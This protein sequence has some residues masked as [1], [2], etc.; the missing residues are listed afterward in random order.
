MTR[1]MKL[2][3]LRGGLSAGLSVTAVLLVILTSLFGQ[4]T[5]L[6]QRPLFL[7]L[8]IVLGYARFPSKGRPSKIRGVVDTGLAILCGLACLA[9]I[10]R[11]DEIITSLPEANVM[12]VVSLA[13]I[14]LALLVLMVRI[15]GWAF[16]IMI[17]LSLIYSLYGNL[18]PGALGH[19]GLDM[20]FLVESLYLGDL[21]LW[22]MLTGVAAT[23]IAPFVL[24]GAMVLCTGGGQAFR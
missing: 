3:R 6:I 12:D 11:A 9:V 20:A 4:F 18:V 19:R 16:P 7:L 5:N 8:I 13:A 1:L 23:T 22:G 24:F 2:E 14:L 10:V 15:V 17:V 21:G